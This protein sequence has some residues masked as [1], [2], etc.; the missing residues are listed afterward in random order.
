MVVAAVH[1]LLPDRLQQPPLPPLGL[2]PEPRRARV[3][4]VSS[5]QNEEVGGIWHLPRAVPVPPDQNLAAD[6]SRRRSVG[7]LTP[8]LVQNLVF[9]S[10][11]LLMQISH[12]E[13]LL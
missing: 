10:M 3:K 2:L 12:F 11:D 8:T 7:N 1:D 9:D 6:A 5:A 4:G 13:V